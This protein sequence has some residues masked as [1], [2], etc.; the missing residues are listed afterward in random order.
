[1]GKA[2]MS[3]EG[4]A[5]KRTLCQVVT[6]Q[7]VKKK[8]SLHPPDLLKGRCWSLQPT[9]T[10]CCLLLILA[11]GHSGEPRLKEQMTMSGWHWP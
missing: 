9:I 2:R 7:V 1:M 6:C 10:P 3:V 11:L 5:A 4:P 8:V